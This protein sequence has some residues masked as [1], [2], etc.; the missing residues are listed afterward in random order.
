MTN[1]ECEVLREQK[2]NEYNTMKQQWQTISSA[3]EERF[4]AFRERKNLIGKSPYIRK[5]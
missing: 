4:S 3:Q 5:M 1:D 2:V